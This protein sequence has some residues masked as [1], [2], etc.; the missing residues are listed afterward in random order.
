MFFLAG[1]IGM[2]AVGSLTVLVTGTQDD[3]EEAETE[4]DEDSEDTPPEQMSMTLAESVLPNAA[5]GLQLFSPLPPMSAEPGLVIEAGDD[6]DDLL[7]D[8]GD[9]FLDGGAGDDRLD[10]Q[11]GDDMLWGGPDDDA[12]MG[13]AD[14][15][16]LH[17]EAGH[18]QMRGDAGNDQM[19]GNAGDDSLWGD[20]G[21]DTLWGGLGAD[22]LQGGSGDDALHGREG[23]DRLVGGTGAD[24]LFGGD[25][26]DI[27]TGWDDDAERDYLN[28]GRGD[29]HILAGAKDIV[30]GGLG[31]DSI[32]LPETLDT[33][34]QLLDFD[35]AEDRL[36]V[37]LDGPDAAQADITFAPGPDN[38]GL[39]ELRVNGQPM[40]L[41]PGDQVPSLDEVMILSQADAALVFP[42]WGSAR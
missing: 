13:G 29:D 16:T 31:A 1:L 15:D 38:S 30:T 23:S 27:L 17:G 14:Q 4:Q 3:L 10:G 7:G 6:D 11:A 12:L 8:Q 26:N 19:F 33:A 42:D 24:S 32:Y 22:V 41:L 37:L 28:G 18:D 40:A 25:G 21:D 5:A 35:S 20:A 9:D 34:A 2:M 36:V 39:T